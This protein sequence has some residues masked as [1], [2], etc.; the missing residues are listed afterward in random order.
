MY[1]ILDTNQWD[2][3][4][5]LRHRLAAPLLF[6]VQNRP[7]VQIGLPTVV[8]R[9]VELHLVEKVQQ[10]QGKLKKASGEV[11]QIFGEARQVEEFSDNQ[12]RQ[13]FAQRLASLGDL[14]E[15]LE[16]TDEELAEAGR[17]VLSY[18]PP[19]TRTSQQYRDSVIW[20]IVI[21]VSADS[22]VYLITADEGFYAGKGTNDLAGNLARE[23]HENRRPIRLFRS[24]EALLREW[25][26]SR[27]DLTDELRDPVADAVEGEVERVL[28]D[29]GGFTITRRKAA[30]IE[31]YLTEVIDQVT[32]SGRFEFYLARSDNPGGFQSA[33]VAEARATATAGISDRKV[34]TVELDN[35]KIEALTA[36][37]ATSISN[38]IFGRAALHAFGSP[39]E[40][41]TLNVK[42][43]DI[44]P[45][46]PSAAG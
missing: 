25:G 39:T 21:R 33:A 40:P 23:A 30:E 45:G 32:V 31:V 2:T 8:K 13:A 6:S 46:S 16:P 12:V 10:A 11:R 18:L 43:D 7:G 37:G 29:Q 3:M 5:M 9:E 35:V 14:V 44:W 19:S 41:Y 38:T 17:M 42:F 27:P 28:V 36:E 1:V 15:V 24:V 34:R 22:D 20:R 26:P 4:P